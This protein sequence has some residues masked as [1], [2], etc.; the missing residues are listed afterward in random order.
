MVLLIQSEKLKMETLLQTINIT[1]ACYSTHDLPTVL[2]PPPPEWSE[3]F[4]Q[5]AT[6]CRLEVSLD[7]AFAL[8]KKFYS[9][10]ISP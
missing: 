9:E 7:Q 10:A 3:T 2:L 4:S 5:L 8:I 6:E 1:F